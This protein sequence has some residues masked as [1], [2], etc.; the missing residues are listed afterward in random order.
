MR[1]SSRSVSWA[2]LAGVL[3]FAVGPQRIAAAEESAAPFQ[4]SLIEQVQLFAAALVSGC[5]R[6][7]TRT[8]AGSMGSSSRA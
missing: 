4:V 8:S 2:M 3:T 1:K 6:L 7:A 5:C